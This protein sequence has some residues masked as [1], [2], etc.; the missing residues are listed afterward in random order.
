MIN[1]SQCYSR[2]KIREMAVKNTTIFIGTIIYQLH[3]SAVIGHLQ[4]GIKR[5]M[6][7]SIIRIG[8]GGRD[9]VYKYLG[10]VVDVVSQL[11]DGLSRPKHV[12]RGLLYL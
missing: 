2:S 8:M 7:I 3:V 9:L 4:V 10:L 12:V 11:E 6:R 1:N 5:H